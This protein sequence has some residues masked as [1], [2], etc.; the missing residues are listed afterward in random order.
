M[1]A[2]QDV[3]ESV[4]AL[5]RRTKVDDGQRYTVEHWLDRELGHLAAG[6]GMVLDFGKSSRHRHALFRKECIVTADINQYDGYPDVV[7]DICDLDTYPKQRFA[8]IVCSSMLEHVYDPALAVRNMHAVLDDGGVLIGQVPFLY[9]YH[10]P[11]DLKYQDFWRFTRDGLALLFKDFSDV[12]LY[13]IRGRYST[14]AN[15]LPH[16]KQ[17]VE[18][19]FGTRINRLLD[20]LPGGKAPNVSGYMIKAVK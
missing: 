19:L 1:S 4:R 15:L 10:A 6:G 9:P 20:L 17:R 12:T 11:D 8:G 18:G 2:T 13:P 5:I 14:M 7:V 16:W 3:N